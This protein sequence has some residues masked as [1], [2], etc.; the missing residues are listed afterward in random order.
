MYIGIY[1]PIIH[2]EYAANMNCLMK[3]DFFKLTDPRAHNTHI[4]TKVKI[5]T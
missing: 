4:F 3:A 5:K 1:L 2:K